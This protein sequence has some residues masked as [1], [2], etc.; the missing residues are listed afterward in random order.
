MRGEG[1]SERPG[2][3]SLLPV[4][5]RWLAGADALDGGADALFG[6]ADALD[7][8]RKDQSDSD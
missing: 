1:R 7:L 8:I 3:P 2:Q 6:G 5:M 4:R